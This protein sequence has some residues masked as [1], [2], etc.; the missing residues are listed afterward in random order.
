[1]AAYFVLSACLKEQ[2]KRIILKLFGC[3]GGIYLAQDRDWWQA[4]VNM[5][6]NLVVS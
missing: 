6:M 3:V 5:E 4:L 2:A 1:L